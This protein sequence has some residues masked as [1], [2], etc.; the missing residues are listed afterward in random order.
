MW[1][2]DVTVNQF[3]IN[4]DIFCPAA[5]ASNEHTDHYSPFVRNE[6]AIFI[7]VFFRSSSFIR[8]TKEVLHMPA[9]EQ[10]LKQAETK[11]RDADKFAYIFCN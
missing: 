6:F 3:Q 5:Y 1:R 4:E 10:V 9:C 7:Q 2:R 11:S 8:S